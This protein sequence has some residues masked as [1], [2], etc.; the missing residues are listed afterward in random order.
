MKLF[1]ALTLSSIS[2][3]ASQTSTIT[4]QDDKRISLKTKSFQAPPPPPDSPPGGRVRGGAKRGSCPADAVKLTALVPFTTPTP[5]V[6]NVWGLTTK[7][8]PTLWLYVPI[9]KSSA[10]PAEFVLQDQDSRP[11]YQ[12]DIN[13][14]EQPGI[15]GVSLPA[16]APPLAVEKRYRWFFTIYCDPE[17]QLPPIYV[18]GV[19]KRVNLNQAIA[20]QL[21]VAQPLQKFSIYAK[22]GIWHEALTTLAELRQQDPQNTTLQSQW[23]DL[24]SSVGFSQEAKHPIIYR[25]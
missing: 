8:R 12:Q 1:L 19:I 7:E 10:Y 13:L 4:T 17:K 5:T 3:L 14:P 11:I 6:T 24:L 9:P 18:E 23:Q 16:N 20:R 15:I 25:Q 2:F 21:K 22:N